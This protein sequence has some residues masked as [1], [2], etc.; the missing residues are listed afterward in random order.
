MLQTSSTGARPSP[1]RQAGISVPDS[2]PWRASFCTRHH[3]STEGYVATMT[4]SSPRLHRARGALAATACL[5]ILAAGCGA[6][7]S[8]AELQS[9]SAGNGASTGAAAG[10]LTPGDQPAA[11]DA[12]AAPA[13]GAAAPGDATA[14]T[15]APATGA[16][17]ATP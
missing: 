12:G 6:R 14:T 16:K 4:N 15:A 13:A 10:E 5:A 7:L 11:T 8:K 2:N 17:A 1:A 9:A 3:S